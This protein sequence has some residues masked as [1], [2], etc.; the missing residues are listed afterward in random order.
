MYTLYNEYINTYILLYTWRGKKSTLPV[1][2]QL[3]TTREGRM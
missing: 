2:G 3:L 1:E